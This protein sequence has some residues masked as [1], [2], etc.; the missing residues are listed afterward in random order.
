MARLTRIPTRRIKTMWFDRCDGMLINSAFGPPTPMKIGLHDG[1]MSLLNLLT[2]LVVLLG[3][4]R[5]M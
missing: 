3:Q 5:S 4:W 2:E 1:D